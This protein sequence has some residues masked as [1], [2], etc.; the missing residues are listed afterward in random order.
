MSLRN[1]TCSFV[2]APSATTDSSMRWVM[3]TI[4]SRMLSLRLRLSPIAS[5]NSMSIFTTSAL[6]SRNMLREE[7]PLPK[8]SMNTENP[9]SL[10]RLTAS[11][12][13]SS[14]AYALSVIS[15]WRID[16]SRPYLSTRSVISRT[17]SMEYRSP[18]E[19]LTQAGIGV[20]PRSIQF[21]ISRQASSHT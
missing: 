5:R 3:L 20:F 1:S 8:S 15:R 9:S 12:I 21:L 13:F 14:S 19:M 18:R 17:I 6:I 11:I 16:R 7:Y 10:N 2:S 4:D